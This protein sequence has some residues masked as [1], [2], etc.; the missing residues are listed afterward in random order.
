MEI[1]EPV[2]AR[3]Q[4]RKRIMDVMCAEFSEDEM[5]HL[6]FHD[7]LL[8][9]VNSLCGPNEAMNAIRRTQINPQ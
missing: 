6:D 5:Y 7:A 1:Y 8:S 4:L 2:K 9:A 3:E